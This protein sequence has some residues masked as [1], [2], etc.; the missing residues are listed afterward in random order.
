M[1]Q[2]IP[3]GHKSRFEAQTTTP[4][5]W[6]F[7]EHHEDIVAFRMPAVEPLQQLA[8]EDSG[9]SRRTPKTEKLPFVTQNTNFRLSISCAAGSAIDSGWVCFGKWP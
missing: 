4:L 1:A 2:S 9:H 3:A 6:R 8:S 5:P 7:R